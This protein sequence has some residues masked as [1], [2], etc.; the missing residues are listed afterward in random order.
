M[1][2]KA[3]VVRANLSGRREKDETDLAELNGYL[4][5]GW[6]V[7]EM[8]PFSGTGAAAHSGAALVVLEQP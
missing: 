6:R 4:A 8:C 5:D 1:A 2:T 3:I 7:V